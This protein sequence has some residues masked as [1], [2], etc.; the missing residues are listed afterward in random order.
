MGIQLM[1]YSCSKAARRRGTT[2]DK[3]SFCPLRGN[4]QLAAASMRTTVL[5]LGCLLSTCLAWAEERCPTAG[6]VPQI[7]CEAGVPTAQVQHIAAVQAMSQRCWAASIAM[8]FQFYGHEVPQQRIVRE[9]FG[10]VV[11]M[12]A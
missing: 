7:L 6:G 10:T 5:F 2:E 4:V 9:T 12:P 8:V 3:G 1:H 11:N